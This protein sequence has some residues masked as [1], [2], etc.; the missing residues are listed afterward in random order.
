MISVC[1]HTHV[2]ECVCGEEG[3]T[4]SVMVSGLYT[5]GLPGL[6]APWELERCQ[7]Y[8]GYRFLWAQEDER[9]LSG[10]CGTH[11]PHLTEARSP[12]DRE[13]H[14]ILLYMS[15]PGGHY[16]NVPPC[17]LLHFLQGCECILLLA[18]QTLH[19]LSH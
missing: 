4:L 3:T 1:M 15:H 17:R 8:R 7:G 12:P 10:L 18:Q 9:R 13:D 5:S 6:R 2:S 11:C 16:S 14:G 19:P